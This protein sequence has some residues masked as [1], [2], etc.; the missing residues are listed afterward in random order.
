MPDNGLA[1]VALLFCP[2]RIT[3]FTYSRQGFGEICTDYF[4]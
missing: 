3:K 1:T 4:N 2:F